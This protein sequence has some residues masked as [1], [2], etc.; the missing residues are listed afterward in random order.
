MTRPGR[1]RVPRACSH[2]AGRGSPAAIRCPGSELP[3]AMKV[4]VTG[5]SG[6][7]G[8]E[9]VSFFDARAAAVVGIDNNM[10]ADFFGREGDTAWNLAHLHNTTRQFR[11]YDL[12]VRD[13]GGLTSLFKN[14]GPFHLIVH[15]A[16]QPSHDLAAKRPFDDFDVNAVGTLNVLEATRLLSPEAVFV[17]MST[18]KVYGDAPNELPLRE[19]P[20]RWEYARR[21]DHDGITEEMRVD[22]SKH[23]VFGASK[24]AADVMTQE[25]GRYFGLRT[26]CL[27]GSCLTG[28]NHSGVELHG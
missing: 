25:Y 10:R 3:A 6:L 19:L 23:T 12:D 28:P 16:A 2:H 26:V 13:R 18:N 20:L 1:A 21:Q 15:C 8:S 9:L 17:L 22:R 11:H 27:R 14:E 24:I 5:S 7:I 4:L